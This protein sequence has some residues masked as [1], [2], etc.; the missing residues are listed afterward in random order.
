MATSRLRRL[1]GREHDEREADTAPPT[2]TGVG[3]PRPYDPPPGAPGVPAPVAPPT[4]QMPPAP[5]ARPAPSPHGSVTPAQYEQAGRD[6]RAADQQVGV[7]ERFDAKL[8]A[9]IHEATE[10]ERYDYVRELLSR[11]IAVRSR[12]EEA[13]LRRNR[14]VQAEED[15]ARGLDAQAARG[16]R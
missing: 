8:T 9:Q 15:I 11:R 6:R 16:R 13:T 14:L 1:F 5:V 4:R 12:L 3:A 10:A 7:F 2:Y